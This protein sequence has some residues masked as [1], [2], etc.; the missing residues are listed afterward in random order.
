MKVRPLG[1]YGELES[2]IPVR[3]TQDM[4]WELN[5]NSGTNN[6][7]F[8]GTQDSQ[9][10]AIRTNATDRVVVD[11][12]G[13]VGIGTSTPASKVEIHA[14][15]GLQIVGFQPFLTLTDSSPGGSR[16]RIQDANRDLVFFT[17]SGLSSGV[18]AMVIK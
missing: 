17:E 6:N 5:G 13:N 2:G 15:D 9:P 4:P 18:P 10:L 11:V 12:N 1:L 14:Q 7:N 3:R 8:L 16:A